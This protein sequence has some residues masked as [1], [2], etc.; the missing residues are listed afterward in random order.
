MVGLD[1]LRVERRGTVRHRF[2]SN[3]I[4]EVGLDLLR[5]ERRT[6]ARCGRQIV[7]RQNAGSRLGSESIDVDGQLFVSDGT[8]KVWVGGR[9]PRGGLLGNLKPTKTGEPG[10]AVFAQTLKFPPSSRELQGNRQAAV[11]LTVNNSMIHRLP[12]TA[13]Q[14]IRYTTY[15][16]LRW[17]HELSFEISGRTSD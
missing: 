17:L 12:L 10:V 3:R 11:P 6:I 7:V 15:L 1:R 9:E 5:A 8:L 14:D 16:N 2:C 4:T 13:S